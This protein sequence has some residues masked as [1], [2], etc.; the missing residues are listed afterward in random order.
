MLLKYIYTDKLE[1]ERLITRYL[2]R[3]DAAAWST[4]FED[5]EGTKYLHVGRDLPPVERAIDWV[6]TCIRRYHEQRFGLQALIEKHTGDFVGLCGL[7]VQNVNAI[8]EVEVG[9]HLLR[10]HRNKGYATEAARLFRDYA[11]ENGIADSVVSIINPANQ[12]SKD[13]A[14]RNGMQLSAAGVSFRD[15][16]YDIFRIN[17]QEWEIQRGPANL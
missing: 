7:L 6:N 10:S 11:F 5:K 17:R 16:I 13:V 3:E 4:F 12:P 14:G 1:S 9:Y 8:S 2:T 15:N